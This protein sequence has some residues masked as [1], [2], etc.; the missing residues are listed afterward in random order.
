MAAVRHLGFFKFEIFTAGRVE[1]INMHHRVELCKIRQTV[2]EI[3]RF[4]GFEN[5]GRLP[6]TVVF[7]IFDA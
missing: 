2:A 5:D 6:S 7:N 3:W 4:N 1:R